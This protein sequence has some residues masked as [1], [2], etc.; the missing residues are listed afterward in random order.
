MEKRVYNF[1][2]GPAVLPL[3]ALEEAQRD[4]LALPGTGISILEISHR[5][6]KFEQILAQAD[7]NLRTLLG[8]PDNY[9]I[10]FLQGGALLQF[11]MIPMSFLRNTGKPADYIVT[12]TWSKKA[13]DEA[14]TQGTVQ[15]AFDG[16]AGNYNRVPKAGRTETRPQRGIRLLHLQRNHPGRAVPR[17]ARGGRRAAGLRRIERYPL[18]ADQREPLWDPLRLRQKN[19]GPAGVTI[20]IIRDDLLAKAPKDLPSLLNYPV[21]AENKSLLNTPPTFA[22][23]MVKLVTDWLLRDIGGLEKMAEINRRKAGM[24]YDVDRRLRRL[25]SAARRD[26]QPLDHERA[27]QA[28]RHLAGRGVPQGRGRLRTGGTQGTPLGR[29]LPGVD[30]QRHARG[31]RRDA[32]RDYMLDFAKKDGLIA[33][34]QG[35]DLD[36]GRNDGRGKLALVKER[37]VVAVTLGLAEGHRRAAA[38]TRDCPR[39]WRGSAQLIVMRMSKSLCSK[40]AFSTVCRQRST[41]SVAAAIS[42]SENITRNRW[43][44]KR[45]TCTLSDRLASSSLATALRISLPAR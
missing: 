36:V 21:L 26:R 23:Y 37:A 32:L 24:L 15:I 8:I 35:L 41:V 6:K 20:V 31:R 3:P 13:A 42:T 1:S 5:S 19:A 11:G 25:L 2:P 29:R 28:G 44:E 17:R 10:L 4:L 12:G 18:A 7:A 30:L 39:C 34:V 16:K 14:K 43:P 9:R 22:I 40:W 33:T 27:V 45:A 38:P